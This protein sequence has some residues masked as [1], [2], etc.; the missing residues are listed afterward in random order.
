LLPFK[1]QLGDVYME[2]AV[3]EQ[4]GHGLRPALQTI[5]FGE[6]L[7]EQ[8][9]ITDEQL[10]DALGEHWS[11]GGNIGSAIARRGYLPTDEVE[12]QA[13]LYHG[14]EIVEV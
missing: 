14:L 7:C 13:A 4:T 12:R 6:F 10:L 3:I 1:A 8:E 11:N 2:K 5:R 9:L